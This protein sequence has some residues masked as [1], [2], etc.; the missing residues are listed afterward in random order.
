MSGKER[1]QA[2][3]MSFKARN[4]SVGYYFLLFYLPKPSLSIEIDGKKVI[5]RK[6][7]IFDCGRNTRVM[8]G[9]CGLPKFSS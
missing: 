7:E 9:K 1:I 4:E 6:M 2:H 8:G 3:A 5:L